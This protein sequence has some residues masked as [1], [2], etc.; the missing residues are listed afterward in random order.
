MR[1]RPAVSAATVWAVRTRALS[2]AMLAALLT[3]AAGPATAQDVPPPAGAASPEIPVAI[4]ADDAARLRVDVEINAVPLRF[5]VDTASTRSVVA[6]EV[7]S[8]MSLPPGPMVT[9]KNIGGSDRVPSVTIPELRFAALS[10]HDVHAPALLRNNL[11]GDGLIGLDIL[12]GQR[13]TI[14]F[15]ANS[16]ITIVPSD[17]HDHADDAPIESGTIVVTAR[18]KRGELILTDAEIEGERVAVIIDTGSEDSVGNEPLR[19]LVS[20]QIEHTPIQPIT[21]LSVTGRTLPADYTQIGHVKIGGFEI[22]NLPIAFA[23]ASS[24]Q[25]FGLARQPAIL[26]G[27]SALRLFD[28]VTLDFT[29]KQ[30]WFRL[31]PH[32]KL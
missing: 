20:R 26:L 29:R 18:S 3:I 11:G 9:V 6:K 15:K 17:R 8:R 2:A 14:N 5:L 24:F 32:P 22:S 13:L 16:T 4:L 30:V 10:I 7:A 21:L 31:R 19:R 23:D 27:M 28:I 25:Q 12:R 1:S